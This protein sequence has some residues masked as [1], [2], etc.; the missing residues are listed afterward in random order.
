MVGSIKNTICDP[1]SENL[2]KT[3]HIPYFMKIEVGPEIGISMFKY[4]AV[5]KWK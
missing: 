2:L 5:K 3:C 4:V 1:L